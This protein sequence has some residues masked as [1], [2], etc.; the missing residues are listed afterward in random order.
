MIERIK[1]Y[2][3]HHQLANSG[4]PILLACSGGMDSMVLA[5]VL[6]KTKHKLSIAHCNFQLRGEE[7]ET[8]EQFVKH[9]AAEHHL[10][11]YS[12]RFD[13]KSY[14]KEHSRSTQMAARDLRYEWLEKIRREHHYHVIAV[15]HHLDDQIETLLLNISKGSGIKGLCGMQPKSG[16]LI[17]PM[18]E[19]SRKEIQHYAL[20]NK[21]ACREDSSN[22][23]DDYQRNQLRHHVVPVLQQIN[24]SLYDSLNAFIARMNDYEQLSEEA[25]A[26]IR[27][28]CYSVKQD[29]VEIKTGYIQTHKAGKTILFHLIK[30]F[31]FN[32]DQLAQIHS[33]LHREEHNGK[34]FLSHT[35]RLVTGRKSIF[36]VPLQL[37][38]QDHLLFEKL[39]HKI[40]FNNYKIECKIV[41][42]AE[43]NT[44]VSPR[45]ACFDLAKVEFPL[46]IRYPE[47]RDYFY[48]FGMSKPKTPGKA[49][50]KKLSKYF[51]DE[52]CSPLEKENTAVLFS[53][54]RLIWVLG[55]RIDDRFKVSAGTKLV[56][57]LTLLEQ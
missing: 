1:A 33:C 51:K 8:D 28:R 39:P 53:G 30:D 12:V 54:E 16:F 45:F 52:K 14:A 19:I 38:R 25:I 42:L 9:Y 34:Q 47:E 36:V 23:S 32:S 46:M 10:S 20:E 2:I 40:L 18:L 26:Q 35:H 11:F 27:K 29:I 15:A 31:G 41:P 57:K 37:S 55:H 3:H 44:R 43:L 17:R 50:K 22:A 21:I 7:S 24:P 5:D 49:G 56:L 4:T 48:P 6:L 13:T